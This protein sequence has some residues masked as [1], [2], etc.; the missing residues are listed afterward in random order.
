MDPVPSG[1]NDSAERYDVPRLQWHD[2]LSGQR[3]DY[4]LPLPSGGVMHP[5]LQF[6]FYHINLPLRVAQQLTETST[7]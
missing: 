2:I 4:S 1:D 5:T 3:Q 6:I 7:K